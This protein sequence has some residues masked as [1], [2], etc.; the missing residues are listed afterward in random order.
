MRKLNQF[1]DK[2]F[3]IIPGYIFGLLAF[4]FGFLGDIL[5]LL[6]S[7]EYQMWKY[8]ISMLGLQTGGIFL[9]SGFIIS[10]IFAIPF[11][12]FFGRALKDENINEFVRKL[13]IGFGI[14]T[15]VSVILTGAFT[16]TTPLLDYL[17][18]VFALLSFIGGAIVC[19]IY[20]FLVAKNSKF[21]KPIRN[22]GI[23][24]S[25]IVASYLIPFFITNFCSFFPNICYSLGE[26]IYI[27]MPTYEWVMIFAI[28]LWYLS[29]SVYMAKK[30]L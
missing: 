6:V 3:S 26:F 16:G 27:I 13:A 24:I 7:P 19:S 29:N 15:S 1:F 17:H 5:A 21:S 14:L 28:L 12:I 20:T 23:V 30:K 11:V 18:G 9:R 25:G 2:L 22:T 10:N 8:S 4:I